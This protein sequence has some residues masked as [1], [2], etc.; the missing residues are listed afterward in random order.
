MPTSQVT[1]GQVTPSQTNSRSGDSRSYDTQS[2]GTQSH[3]SQSHGSGQVTATQVIPGQVTPVWRVSPPPL[4]HSTLPGT[5]AGWMGMEA[6]VPGGGSVWIPQ[7]A[8]S[9]QLPFELGAKSMWPITGEN[10][11]LVEERW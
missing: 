6:G 4:T 3:G 1:P 8:S 7:G 5:F 10:R 2:H 9:V 11:R